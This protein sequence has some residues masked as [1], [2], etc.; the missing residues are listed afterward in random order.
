MRFLGNEKVVHI[1]I[2]S[3]GDVN[4]IDDNGN[5]PLHLAVEYGV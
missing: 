2:E 5:T 1:L 3:G 4:S